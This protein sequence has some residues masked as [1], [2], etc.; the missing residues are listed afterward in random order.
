MRNS[1]RPL[2]CPH[3]LIWLK[4]VEPLEI[5]SVALIFV[6]PTSQKTGPVMP[7]GHSSN[8]VH[9]EDGALSEAGFVPR[10]SGRLWVWLMEPTP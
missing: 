4:Y 3:G 7:C 10:S 2:A 9:A 6:A 1:G 8:R 5:P